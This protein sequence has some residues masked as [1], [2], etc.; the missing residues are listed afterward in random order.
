MQTN[1]LTSFLLWVIGYQHELGYLQVGGCYLAYFLVEDFP[2]LSPM[3]HWELLWSCMVILVVL[4]TGSGLATTHVLYLF[5]GMSFLIL[6]VAFVSFLMRGL[7]FGWVW[8]RLIWLGLKFWTQFPFQIKLSSHLLN[9]SGVWMEPS[10]PGVAFDYL[11]CSV[12]FEHVGTLHGCYPY[13]NVH[14]FH[15]QMTSKESM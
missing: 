2:S 9:E 15:W 13:F 10:A 14:H 4:G 3:G 12:P 5:V 11:T 1:F 8:S 7:V 6:S